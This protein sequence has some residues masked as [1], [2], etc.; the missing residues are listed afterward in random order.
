M[1]GSKGGNQAGGGASRPCPIPSPVRRWELGNDGRTDVSPRPCY[2]MGVR[3]VIPET[4]SKSRPPAV[5]DLRPKVEDLDIF[6][7]SE[8]RKRSLPAIH[9]T[10]RPTA[11]HEVAG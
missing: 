11:A 9:H 5:S 3:P 1:G 8:I 7:F 6:Y 2:A 4:V 10:V